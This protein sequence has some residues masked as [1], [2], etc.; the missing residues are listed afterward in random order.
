ME[1]F[2]EKC[3]DGSYWKSQQHGAPFCDKENKTLKEKWR[4]KS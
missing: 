2:Y 1:S 4:K 3:F